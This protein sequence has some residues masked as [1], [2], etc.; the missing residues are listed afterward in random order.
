[1]P[2]GRIPAGLTA[3]ELMKLQTTMGKADDARRKASVEPVLGTIQDVPNVTDK[4]FPREP[5]RSY[6]T[7]EPL[8][9]VEEIAGSKR[10]PPGTTQQMRERMAELADGRDPPI[11]THLKPQHRSR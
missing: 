4:R 8:G 10:P 6:R 3:N 11:G 2:R 5:D 9:V 1:M 7:T